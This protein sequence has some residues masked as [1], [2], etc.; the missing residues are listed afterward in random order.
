MTD[1]EKESMRARTQT[2]QGYEFWRVGLL[3]FRRTSDG[4]LEE[5][6]HDLPSD[7]RPNRYASGP[8]GYMALPAAPAAPG[9]YMI[10][11][12]GDI[13]YVGEGRDL[14]E[15]FG[16]MGYGQIH[17]RNCHHDGQS[18]NCK[19]N[20]LVLREAKEGRSVEVWFRF[21]TERKLLEAKLISELT[22][23]WNGRI[24]AESPEQEVTSL[25]RAPV[26]RERQAGNK[27]VTAEEF[28][29]ALRKIFGEAEGENKDVIVVRAGDLH[30]TVGGYPGRTHRMP[31]CCSAM[32]SVMDSGD[33]IVQQPPQGNGAN[34][35]IEYRL[36]RRSGGVKFSG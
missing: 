14:A 29:S 31:V 28:R 3:E 34:L 5:Y 33:R 8:F 32:R 19:L 26:A 10:F 20:A 30:K 18:T 24:V 6:T 1:V 17:P 35:Y 15:R 21:S 7:V 2:I 22:P 27:G 25:R 4:Y 13:R 11:V 16:S 36:P 9:V 23:P 12:D